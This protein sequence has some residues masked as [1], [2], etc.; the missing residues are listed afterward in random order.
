L[1]KKIVISIIAVILS[2]TWADAQLMKRGDRKDNLITVGI[3]FNPMIPNQLLGNNSVNILDPE[4]NLDYNITPI[5]ST[6]YGM[7]IRY[8]MFQLINMFSI[9]TGIYYTNRNYRILIDDINGGNR[10]NKI[11]DDFRM[12]AY[13]IPIMG[14]LYIQLSRDIFMNVATGISADFFPS[15][16]YSQNDEYKQYTA[17]KNWVVP[18][19]K[20]NVGWEFRTEQSGFFYAGF[21]Y[22]RPMLGIADTFVNVNLGD[23]FTI[24][25]EQLSGIYFSLD[26]K[27]F[28]D[29]Y[30]DKKSNPRKK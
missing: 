27:Y 16:V 2:T 3:E 19:W 17:R 21:T 1:S 24:E 30:K 20:T 9:Q 25:Q 8:D 28:F 4:N 29:P 13:E 18:S 12:I 23:K 14:L 22:H 7:T 11:S 5:F 15:H 26:F 10:V 6:R